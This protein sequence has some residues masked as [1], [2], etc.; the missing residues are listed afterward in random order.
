MRQEWLA[1]V[2]VQVFF[3]KGKTFL[4][5]HEALSGSAGAEWQVQG[6][7]PACWHLLRTIPVS[8]WHPP[9]HRVGAIQGGQECEMLAGVEGGGALPGQ[10][11]ATAQQKWQQQQQQ[12]QE[13]PLGAAGLWLTAQ[14]IVE[15]K[16]VRKKQEKK[17]FK[18]AK[19]ESKKVMRRAALG[20]P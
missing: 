6:A 2:F 13:Q 12:Q 8:P 7:G 11:G 14:Q 10:Q 3:F 20:A 4:Q 9:L 17:A 16:R 1:V 5:R 19:K 18:K 15:L